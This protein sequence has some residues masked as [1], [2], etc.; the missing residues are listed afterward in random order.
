MENEMSKL[1]KLGAA[2]LLVLAVAGHAR[3]DLLGFPD[4]PPA[5]DA[6]DAQII[7]RN[8]T[9]RS[10]KETDPWLVRRTL[11]ALAKAPGPATA[12]QA[13]GDRNPDPDLD[14]LRTSPE[15]LNDLFQVFKAAA[16][17]RTGNQTK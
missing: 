12:S 9:L 2:A 11:D 1:L 15:A 14:R 8:A 3:A 6:K 10:L 5:F 13:P 17:Q 16:K 4:A 7:A